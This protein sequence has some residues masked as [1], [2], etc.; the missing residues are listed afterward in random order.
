[1]CGDAKVSGVPDRTISLSRRST[2]TITTNALGA[3]SLLWFPELL[4]DNTAQATTLFLNNAGAYDGS[5]VPANYVAQYFSQNVTQNSVS[6]YRLVSAAIRISPQSSV[7]N[8]QGSMYASVHP[9][10][11]N[12]PSVTGGA[13]GGSNLISLI[14][15]IEQNPQYQ[16]CSV[17]AMQGLRAVWAPNDVC[18][19]EFNNINT[20]IATGSANTDSSYTII[21]IIAGAS[22]NQNFKVD[23]YTNYEVH[24]AF[25]SI[26]CGMERM[27]ANDSPFAPVWKNHIKSNLVSVI[28]ASGYINP[29]LQSNLIRSGVLMNERRP[30]YSYVNRT[31]NSIFDI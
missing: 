6:D 21:C 4:S 23:L 15:N 16:T 14:P 30:N 29:T 10:L 27:S 3:H 28:P 24:S 1:M 5:T 7:L 11:V 8:Q 19:L 25:G 17:S 18:Q 12:P 31:Q 22:T 2:F 20:N 13:Y 9:L 26:L